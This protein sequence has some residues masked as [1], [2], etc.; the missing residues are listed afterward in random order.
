MSS[1]FT[2]T[3]THNLMCKQDQTCL[4]LD[5]CKISLGNWYNAHIVIFLFFEH[6]KMINT[7]AANFKIPFP[8]NTMVTTKYDV[9]SK[10]SLF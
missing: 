6:L 9:L 3:K 2:I 1:I 7:K 4:G 8:Q 5:S 10:V